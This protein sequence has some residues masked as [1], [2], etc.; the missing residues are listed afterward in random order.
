[1]N[2]EPLPSLAPVLEQVTPSVV[3]I[4]TQ[5]R[6]RVRS[7]LMDDPFFRRFFN[8]PDV[9]RERVSQSLG[10]GV[11]VDDREGFVITNN[12]V[13]AGADDIS[14]T[15][16]DGRSFRAEVIGTDPD[17]DLAM[18]RIPAKDLQALPF[19]DSNRLRVGD[20]VVAVGNP[21]GLGQTVTSG[22]VS[23]LGRTGVRGLEFQNFIQ[24][25]ASIN[26]G[27]SG[28]AL[29]NLR[30]ELVGINS[31]IF[32]PSGGNVGIGFAIPSAMVR[33]VMDQLSSFG[34]V[35]R[36]TLGLS[37]QN[38]TDDLAGAFDLEK[39]KGVLVAEVA[40]GSAAEKAGLRAGDVIQAIAGYPVRNAQEFHN[41]EGQFPV[42]EQLALEIIRNGS[43][44]TLRVEVEE[45]KALEGET[46]DWRLDG[47]RF[48]E[49]PLK[50][51]TDAVKGVLLSELDADSRLAATGLRP[52][53]IITA[54]N[55]ARIQ[56]LAEFK[57]VVSAVRGALYF[58]V[59]RNGNDYVVRI[60]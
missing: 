25:D 35:R 59:R 52:G 19:A 26:P 18:V 47:A 15:L 48:E 36:G 23:A 1:M 4:Y 45:L 17:T 43:P 20:F 24:T 40:A 12:H 51:R 31:A 3:N 27:N 28:G 57:D 9:P 53:D 29:I 2:G 16:S 56:D 5:T 10:S 41:Y 39:G 34:E 13:I 7:P 44:T 21:F 49:L 22:I 6:V 32:T 46:V 11:I 37:V 60:D 55:R 8:I 30:G 42:G 58:Q 38:L 54:C 14:V 50:Q 33:Y